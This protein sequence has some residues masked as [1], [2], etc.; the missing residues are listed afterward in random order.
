MGGKTIRLLLNLATS[1]VLGRFYGARFMGV[2]F[3]FISVVTLLTVPVELGMHQGV[4]KMASLAE[5]RKKQGQIRT[6]LYFAV[7]SSLLIW[8]LLTA[9]LFIFQK[10]LIH[11]L[12][13]LR[14]ATGFWIFTI[15]VA[16]LV[17]V[18]FGHYRGIFLGLGRVREVV[19]AE[20]II[21]PLIICLSFTLLTAFTKISLWI[22]PVVYIF[23]SGL[24]LFF[25]LGKQKKLLP[26]SRQPL[27]W[28]ERK[29]FLKLSIPFCLTGIINLI[30][31]WT[32]SLFISYYSSTSDVGIYY[33]ASRV[34]TFLPFLMVSF[35]LILPTTIVHMHHDGQPHK[36]FGMLKKITQWNLLFS[37][38]FY[39]VFIIFR[40]EIVNFFGSEFI[41][42]QLPLL[43][44]GAA[45]VFTVATGPNATVLMMT[46]HEQRVFKTSAVTGCTN[47]LLDFIL[48]PWLG[49]NGAALATGVSLILHNLLLLWLCRQHLDNSPHAKRSAMLIASFVGLS[50]IMVLAYGKM[51]PLPSLFVLIL[52]V[53]FLVWIWLDRND[54]KLLRQI[55]MEMSKK[56]V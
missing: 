20:F 48:I 53:A 38:S 26:V 8:L 35:N 7:G 31:Y 28:N 5:M 54:L 56:A 41:S 3:L 4:L 39:S 13:H 45:Q 55:L 12:F 16:V 34:A 21:Q 29:A 37:L 46:G 10:P 30:M 44:L 18:L 2:Y 1:V 49:I 15:S 14:I 24:G 23:A 19:L 27:Q 40:L 36:M 42:A 25:L 17:M 52:S 6:Y 11:N 33:A 9:L 51:G 32:D 22:V 47:I 50:L 43:L